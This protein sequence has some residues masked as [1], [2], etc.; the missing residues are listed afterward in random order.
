MTDVTLHP[1]SDDDLDLLRRANT[2]ELMDQLGG[3]ESD[4][5]MVARHER[6]LRNTRSLA[7]V[8]LLL[9]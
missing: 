7:R 8:A 5:Q 1:W 4:E 6:Y 9:S 2:H 3:P